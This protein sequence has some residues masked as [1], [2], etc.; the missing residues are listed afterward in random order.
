[1]RVTIIQNGLIALTVLL[2]GAYIAGGL[3]VMIGDASGST[4]WEPSVL[5]VVF[6]GAIPIAAGPMILWG[7]YISKRSQRL[8]PGLVAVGAVVV[9]GA[10]FWLAIFLVPVSI[11][12]IAFAVFRARKFASGRNQVSL[13]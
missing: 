4:D 10:W 2:A 6:L 7:L 3:S 1:M 5:E 11:V 9:T 12:V 8:G 13:T